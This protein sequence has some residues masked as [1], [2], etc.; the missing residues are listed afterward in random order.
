MTQLKRLSEKPVIFSPTFFIPINITSAVGQHLDPYK[1][2]V[3][4]SSS[5]QVP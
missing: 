5:T 2:K 3:D 1:T 4:H